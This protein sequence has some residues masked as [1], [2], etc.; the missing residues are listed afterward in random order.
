MSYYSTD[1]EEH[2]NNISTKNEELSYDDLYSSLDEYLDDIETLE[3]MEFNDSVKEKDDIHQ[4]LLDGE[5]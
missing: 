4:I 1:S 3:T 2:K 5:S